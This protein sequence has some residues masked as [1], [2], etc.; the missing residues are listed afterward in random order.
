MFLLDAD[1]EKQVEQL[2]AEQLAKV[3]THGLSVNRV[4]CTPM[5]CLGTNAILHR[6]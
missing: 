2:V 6:D 1:V 4:S 5:R 3:R